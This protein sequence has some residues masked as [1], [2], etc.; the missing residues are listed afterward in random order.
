LP[1]VEF[2]N[3]FVQRVARA[4]DRD[5]LINRIFSGMASPATGG[6]VPPAIA[7]HSAGIGLA[8]DPER[9][10]RT[11]AEAGYPNGLDFPEVDLLVNRGPELISAVGYLQAQWQAHL[12]VNINPRLADTFQAFL[13][14]VFSNAPPAMCVNGWVADYPDADNFLRIFEFTRRHNAAFDQLLET[15]GHVSDQVERTKMYQAA[16]HILIE[17]APVIPLW[18]SRYHLLVKPWISHFRLSPMRGWHWREVVIEP[19]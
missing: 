8:Y 14:R 12:G 1:R 17:E 10:R 11:L 19:H 5:A 9:A 6:I 7:G 18:H 4:G 3:S 2:R 16:D 15:A 13:E